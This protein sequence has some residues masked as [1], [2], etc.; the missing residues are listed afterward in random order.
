MA[1]ETYDGEKL[2]PGMEFFAA[3][4]PES[5]SKPCMDK[6]VP[7]FDS[8][9]YMSRYVNP[10]ELVAAVDRACIAIKALEDRGEV[11]D[12]IAFRGCSGMMMGPLIAVKA[13]KTMLMVRKPDDGSHSYMVVEGDKGARSYLIVDDFVDSGATARAIKDE[14]LK[15]APHAKALGVL[16]VSRLEYE[17]PADDPR[18]K[19]PWVVKEEE[20]NDD[21]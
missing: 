4:E 12:A 2:L 13:N 21:F 7:E 10:T 6:H 8:C 20:E 11:I 17:Q 3:V 14:V 16:E 1:D 9:G 5:L 19:R 18:L 15:F